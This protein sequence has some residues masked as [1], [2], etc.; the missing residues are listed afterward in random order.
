MGEPLGCPLESIWTLGVAHAGEVPTPRPE[1]AVDD[2]EPSRVH[3]GIALQKTPGTVSY[4]ELL[5]GRGTLHPVVDRARSC[6]LLHEES[7]SAEGQVVMERRQVRPGVL[8]S[9][10]HVIRY[11]VAFELL[12]E[13]AESPESRRTG[14]T[15]PPVLSER[16]NVACESRRRLRQRV[17]ACPCAIPGRGRAQALTPTGG[18]NAWSRRSK[19]VRIAGDKIAFTAW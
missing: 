1:R 4:R 6:V 15:A 14:A 8:D 3:P 12:D 5:H 9:G 17:P 19:M 16:D 2:D 13:R 18:P 7:E 10:E 11:E